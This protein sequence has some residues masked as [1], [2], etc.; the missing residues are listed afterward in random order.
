M[1]VLV[2]PG[3]AESGSSAVA[4]S[5]P[6]DWRGRSRY[7]VP[8][9]LN[10]PARSPAHRELRR[11]YRRRALHHLARRQGWMSC[12]HSVRAQHDR[13]LP[14][15]PPPA[16]AICRLVRPQ[17]PMQ[18]PGSFGFGAEQVSPGQHGG[19]LGKPGPGH[20]W[21]CGAHTV[22]CACAARGAT[23]VA[24]VGTTTAAAAS[25]WSVCRR[26]TPLAS[27]R[28]VRTPVSRWARRARPAPVEWP[29]RSSARPAPA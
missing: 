24:T 13:K 26:V 29:H 2:R 22:D 14:E 17:G 3:V 4:M 10:S 27:G 1:V 19:R 5:T 20:S 21:S 7:P 25:R 11:L 12:D 23:I 9:A 18:I 16:P 15:T 28:L 8:V 6:Q